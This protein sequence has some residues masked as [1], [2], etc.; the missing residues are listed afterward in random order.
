MCGLWELSF[1]AASQYKIKATTKRKSSVQCSTDTRRHLPHFFSMAYRLP[2]IIG[3]HKFKL[4]QDNTIFFQVSCS[5]GYDGGLSQ[6]FVVE[7]KDHGNF[8]IVSQIQSSTAPTFNVTGLQPGTAYILNVFS[9]VLINSSSGIGS[10][11]SS[12]I[13]TIIV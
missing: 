4:H 10:Y 1:I 8:A 3:N 9:Q 12:I 5:A 13:S 7:T 6:T 2:S 11:I